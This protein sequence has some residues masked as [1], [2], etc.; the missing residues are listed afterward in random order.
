M[1]DQVLKKDKNYHGGEKKSKR[2]ILVRKDRRDS[3][4]HPRNLQEA[5]ILEC[6]DGE[7][8]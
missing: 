4:S 7:M 2:T 8:V 1:A 3:L 5:Q 6:I